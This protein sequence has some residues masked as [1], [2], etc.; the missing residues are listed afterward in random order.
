MMLTPP[1]AA[2]CRNVSPSFISGRM[3]LTPYRIIS[4]AFL[5][6]IPTCVASSEV[7]ETPCAMKCWVLP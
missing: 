4:A 7:S 2:A 6:R 5:S 3:L 1:D